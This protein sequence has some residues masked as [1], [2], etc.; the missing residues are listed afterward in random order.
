MRPALAREHRR[1]Q[2]ARQRHERRD[3]ELENRVSSEAALCKQPKNAQLCAV[4][5][6]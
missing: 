3:V 6:R 5:V 1:Q 4:R 2:R